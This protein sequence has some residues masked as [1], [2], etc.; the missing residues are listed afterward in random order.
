MAVRSVLQNWNIDTGGVIQADGSGL[1]RYNLITPDAMVAILT[2]VGRD[3]R[4]RYAFEASLPVAGR[5]GTLENR[6]RGTRAEGSARVKTGSLTGVRAMAGYVRS[7][8][9][10]TLAFAIFANN[11]DNSSSAINA[12]CDAIVVRLASYPEVTVARLE[13]PQMKTAE[14]ESYQDQLLSIRQDATG[15]MSGLS[16]AQFNWQPEP[17]RWSMSGCFDHLNLSAA[18]LFMPSID[19]AIATARAQNLKSNGPFVYSAFERWCVRT[20]DAPPRHAFPGAQTRAA[21]CRASRST[22]FEPRFSAGRT[23]SANA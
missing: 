1:S 16:D 17:G 8:D 23:S 12:A 2:H 18:N 9:G 4:L 19:A 22:R 15:L 5:N 3:E 14:I 7:A 13:R 6:M 20:N 10:E 21:R 11:Y